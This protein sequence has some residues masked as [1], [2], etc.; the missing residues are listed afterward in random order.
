MKIIAFSSDKDFHRFYLSLK[1]NGI[2]VCLLI[3]ETS[4]KQ[5]RDLKIKANPAVSFADQ[6]KIQTITP[7]TFDLDVID[8]IVD[9][10]AEIGFVFSYGKIIPQKIIDLFPFGIINIHPS[11]LPK[12][13]GPSP[14]QQALLDNLNSTGYSIMKIDSKMDSG[15]ILYQEKT[16]IRSDDTFDSLREKILNKAS[17]KLPIIIKEYLADKITP[18]KQ[19]D[20]K[21]TYTKMVFKN[22]GLINAEKSALEA[23]SKIRAYSHWP[24]TYLLIEN[25]RFIIHEAKITNNMLSIVKIQ[26]EGKK[27]MNF[28]DFKNGYHSLLTKFPN[29]VNI[30]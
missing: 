10:K 30:S 24:K 22:D 5:G 21:A 4:K 12:Y 6:Y 25:K 7:E 28:S 2:D 13:R 19:N 26:P 9:S 18:V 11:I 27:I 3:S 15:N 23:Y 1:K 29:F 17:I 8:K 14:I 16:A 20:Q